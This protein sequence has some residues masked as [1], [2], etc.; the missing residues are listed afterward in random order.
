[1][2]QQVLI[3][4]EDIQDE[5][6][7]FALSLVLPSPIL[8]CSSTVRTL[9]ISHEHCLLM[10]Y[11]RKNKIKKSYLDNEKKQV[12]ALDGICLFNMH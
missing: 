8:G 10:T 3:L 9:P 11:Q 1:M 5:F 6:C 4:K 7:R 12:S 2:V